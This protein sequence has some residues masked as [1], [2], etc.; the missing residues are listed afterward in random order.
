MSLLLIILYYVFAILVGVW[1][2]KDARRRDEN[3][4]QWLFLILIGNVITLVVWLIVRPDIQN[5]ERIHGVD[6]VGEFLDGIF[7]R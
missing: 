4:G 2:Y 6:D 5:Y 1:I 3:P 7:E